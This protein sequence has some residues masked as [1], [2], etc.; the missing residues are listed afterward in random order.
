[1]ALGPGRGTVNMGER[2]KV[3]GIGNRHTSW[4]P[5][6]IDDTARILSSI[7][8]RTKAEKMR[9]R[10]KRNKPS[11]NARERT[12]NY[13]GSADCDWLNPV[14][15]DFYPGNAIGYL[16]YLLGFLS[17]QRLYV[18]SYRGRSTYGGSCGRRTENS[19][20]R[21]ALHLGYYPCMGFT[22]KTRAS[23]VPPMFSA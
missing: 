23:C 12:V 13:C 15:G 22:Y 8:A 17:S 3:L 18:N 20:D 14:R 7:P 2:E 5:T 6:M 4:T 19:V 11:V 9:A 16:P 21:K 1:M 10:I